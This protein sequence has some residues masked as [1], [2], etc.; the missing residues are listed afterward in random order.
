MER[1]LTRHAD[2]SGVWHV[3]AQP[4]SKYDLLCALTEK[5]QCHDL[6]IEE[7]HEFVCDRSLDASRFEAHTGYVAPT[8]NFMLDELVHCIE[9]RN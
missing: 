1:V 6:H 5:L 9:R 2:L 7:D 4:T 8:W 3:A